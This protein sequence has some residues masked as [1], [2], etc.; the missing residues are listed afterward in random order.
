[1]GGIYCTMPLTQKPQEFVAA[2]LFCPVFEVTPLSSLRL[3]KHTMATEQPWIH[4]AILPSSQPGCSEG[5]REEGQRMED[6]HSSQASMYR[7]K[8]GTIGSSPLISVGAS[9][10]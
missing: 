10:L 2:L 8:S 6:R 9:S 1:M 4:A 5:S 3:T 7:S